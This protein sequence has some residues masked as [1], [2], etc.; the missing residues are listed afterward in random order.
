MSVRFRFGFRDDA[1]NNHRNETTDDRINNEQVEEINVCQE[2]ADGWSNDP[3]QVS[4][5]TQ[6]AEAFLPLLFGQ[7]I[8]D[9]G[10]MCG[11]C[12][13][14]KE[15]N[16]DHKREQ[17]CEFVDETKSKCADG[18]EDQTKQDQLFPPEFIGQ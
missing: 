12:H 4:N 15:P 16:H 17:E 1:I 6:D 7:D 11:L 2:T 18:T 14:R 13:T 5:H 8:C 3:C 9:H 10:L